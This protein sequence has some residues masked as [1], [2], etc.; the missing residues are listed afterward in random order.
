MLCVYR[1]VALLSFLVGRIPVQ[2]L[3]TRF[4]PLAIPDLL[5]VFGVVLLI[6]RAARRELE[7]E[8]SVRLGAVGVRIQEHPSGG[9]YHEHRRCTPVQLNVVNRNA[10]SSEF[11]YA[12]DHLATDRPEVTALRTFSAP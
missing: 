3:S 1:C 5:V 11:V 2:E 6:H 9:R 7:A 12:L 4:Y 10:P 8:A